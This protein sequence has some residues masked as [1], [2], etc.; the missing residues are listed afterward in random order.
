MKLPCQVPL[1]LVACLW[2]LPQKSRAQLDRQ[3]LDLEFHGSIGNAPSGILE[4]PIDQDRIACGARV[5][6]TT[7]I[8]TN[9][10]SSLTLIYC[11]LLDWNDQVF[12]ET[13]GNPIGDSHIALCPEMHFVNGAQAI[14]LQHK[15][16][17]HVL[18]YSIIGINCN[19]FDLD[20]SSIVQ[21]GKESPSAPKSY[22]LKQ[23][24]TQIFSDNRFLRA[25]EGATL[26]DDDS[27]EEKITD[28]DII[29][30]PLPPRVSTAEITGFWEAGSSGPDIQLSLT[31]SSTVGSKTS[32]VKAQS[33]S[34]STSVSTG[35]TFAG[36]GASTDLT[37]TTA[38]SV[39]TAIE[40][41]LSQTESR[42][43][44]VSCGD[45]NDSP[46]GRWQL[47]QW[48]MTQSD[49]ATGIG[50]SIATEHFI[51]TSSLIEPPRCP[52]AYCADRF[53]QRCAS[54]F[55]ELGVKDD[56]GGGGA[57]DSDGDEDDEDDE[58]CFSFKWLSGFLPF[59]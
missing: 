20:S 40:K 28:I 22:A 7:Y 9:V 2:I 47:W 45:P 35:F 26:K 1:L 6:Q 13:L 34:F 5:T 57:D 36:V 50:F 54:P 37:S 38:S 31:V 41:T 8:G 14:Y 24:P 21:V 56:A 46:S 18:F 43:I 4:A 51:C 39:S 55:E 48:S 10:L 27:S 19:N 12:G 17:G 25:V 11:N 30:E 53:C 33:Y 29:G 3:R 52:V 42:T 23:G 44:S 32:F 59:N 49:D 58:G 16:L 15:F